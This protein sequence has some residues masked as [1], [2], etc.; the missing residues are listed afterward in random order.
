M[1]TKFTY[2]LSL[3]L[4][5]MMSSCGSSKS[6]VQQTPMGIDEL[7]EKL[8]ELQNEGWKINGSTRTLRGALTTHY[9]RL[10]ENPKLVELFGQST[11]CVSITVCR[12]AALTAAATQ[13][14]KT[15][16]QELKGKAMQDSGM[17]EGTTSTDDEYNKFMDASIAR[18]EAAIKGGI[19]E[20]FSVIQP[21]PN[22]GNNYQ[23]YF[24]LDEAEAERKAHQAIKQ[25]L[26]ASQL[27][28][29]YVRSIE[30]FINE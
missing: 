21:N 10:K 25:D 30:K 13:L 6:T 12:S 11:G 24:I 3:I 22:G 4:I 29:E 5:I 7:T 2:A 23:M 9:D 1:K 19:I 16:G 8:T 14:A 27:R 20:S 26:E 17:D 18:Y 28:Q 15:K